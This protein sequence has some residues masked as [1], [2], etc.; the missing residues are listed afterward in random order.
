MVTLSLQAGA[1]IS[2]RSVSNAVGLEIL[3]DFI[4]ANA[5]QPN[6]LSPTTGVDVTALSQQE[7]L[8]WVLDQLLTMV[9]QS[10]NQYKKKAVIDTAVTTSGVE[11]RGWK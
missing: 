10:A 2:T 6:S 8:D 3:S 7:Q 9:V 1:V 4:K 5:H 11:G